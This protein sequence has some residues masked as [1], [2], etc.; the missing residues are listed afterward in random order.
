MSWPPLGRGFPLKMWS[1]SGRI[2]GEAACRG[3]GRECWNL[4]L[5]LLSWQRASEGQ[6]QMRNDLME[7]IQ[8]KELGK[9]SKVAHDV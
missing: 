7:K 1:L 2:S 8:G 6:L 9:E 4:Q 5:D 3:R